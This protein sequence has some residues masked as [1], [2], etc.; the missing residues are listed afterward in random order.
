M[1]E[2]HAL[3]TATPYIVSGTY[4]DYSNGVKQ[5]G[6]ALT[7]IVLYERQ[8]RVENGFVGI[9][10]K[11]QISTTILSTKPDRNATIVINGT[12]Y[13]FKDPV[14]KSNPAFVDFWESEVKTK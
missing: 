11:M 14:K 2:C 9:V 5:E 6:V 1:I 7:N 10:R 13:S 12:T 8:E 3:P 4:F